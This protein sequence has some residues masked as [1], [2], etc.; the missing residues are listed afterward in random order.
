MCFS[1]TASFTAAAVIGSIGVVTWRAAKKPG[2]KFLGAVPFLF[3]VQQLAEG[4][5]WLSFTKPGWSEM[6]VPAS[7]GFLSFAWIIW[8]ILIPY[9]VLKLEHPGIRREMLIIL[10]II[11]LVSGAYALFLMLFAYP[12]PVIEKFHIDYRIDEDYRSNTLSMVRQTAY[13]F[14]TVVALFISSVRGMKVLAIGNLIALGITYFFY[15]NALPSTWCF[16][17][18]ILS[19]IIYWIIQI[20]PADKKPEM[21]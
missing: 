18:A 16:F 19:L 15:R 12:V 3:A 13:V 21:G 10:C 17:A 4:I 8:P 14:S 7:L 2:E 20:Q 11:G 1:A 5:V 6:Q 9:A